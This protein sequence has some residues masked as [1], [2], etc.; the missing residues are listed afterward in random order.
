[1]AVSVQIVVFWTVNLCG[2]VGGYEE[3]YVSAKCWYPPIRPY[4]VNPEDHNLNIIQ[5]LTV[6]RLRKVIAVI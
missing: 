3:K 2:L 4:G 5:S 1:M 6:V